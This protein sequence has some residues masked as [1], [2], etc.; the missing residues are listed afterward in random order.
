[1]PAARGYRS[2][3]GIPQAQI[4]RALSVQICAW[5]R[6]SLVGSIDLSHPWSS[7]TMAN[8]RPTSALAK[9]PQR[10]S[11][12]WA[13]DL[14]YATERSRVTPFA[15]LSSTQHTCSSAWVI[16]AP[17]ERPQCAHRD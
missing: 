15:I 2:T 17:Q 5:L 3:E 6:L 4:S 11:Y 12:L 16:C 14:R 7:S 10:E 9:H 8:E 1:M 13:R